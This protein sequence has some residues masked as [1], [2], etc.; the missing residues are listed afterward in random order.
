MALVLERQADGAEIKPL[1]LMP[2]LETEISCRLA[3][4]FLPSA[5]DSRRSRSLRCTRRSSRPSLVQEKAT[6]G[7]EMAMRVRVSPTWPASVSALRRNFSRAGVLKKSCSTLMTV[8]GAMPQAFTSFTRPPSTMISV[9]S[10]LSA[11]RLAS[12]KRETEAMEG[13]ASP[14]KPR[15]LMPSRSLSLLILL[16]A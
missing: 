13:R 9:P 15:V 3:A 1:M 14:R 7:R 6:S 11:S 12:R 2:L 4:V 5:W 16:V 10:W 8:P